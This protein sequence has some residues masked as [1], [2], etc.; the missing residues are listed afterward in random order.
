MIQLDAISKVHCVGIGG[1]GVSA[2]ARMMLDQGKV[3]SGSDR[4]TSTLLETLEEEGVETFVG[5]DVANVSEDVELLVYSPAIPESNPER[6]IA[7]EYGIPELSYPE[8][9]GL[10]SQNMFTVAISGTHGKTTTTAM[11][12]EILIE[13]GLAPT[14]IVGSLLTKYNSNYVSG[15]GSIFVVEACEY[16]RSF[17]HLS[18]DIF[19]ITNIE[20]DHLDYYK[21][22]ADIQSAFSDVAHRIKEGGVVVANVCHGSVGPVIE[23]VLVDVEDYSTR[24]V[25]ESVTLFGKHNYENAKAALAVADRLR[26]DDSVAEKALQNFQGTWRRM[27]NK[28]LLSS[29]AV[30]IDD[31]A[32]HP[33]EIQTTLAAI[34]EVYPTHKLTVIFQPHLYSRTKTLLHD[35]GSA[36]TDADSVYLVPIYE[37]REVDDGTVSHADVIE[38]IK[39]HRDEDSSQALHVSSSMEACAKD[40]LDSTNAESVVVTMGAGDVYTMF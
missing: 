6:E 24:S 26:V 5:H 40:V 22:L 30:W 20:E 9:L 12:A 13:A 8:V 29:G 28:G 31:Y 11:I 27:E 14:V 3:V 17:T 23:D 39:K 34:R 1:I 33:T 25:P 10:I 7:R 21:D 38:E 36:F 2:F 16:K 19:V 15:N 35:F 37:A 18:P 4:E 32:H